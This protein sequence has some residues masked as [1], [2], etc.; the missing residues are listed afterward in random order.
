MQ[1]RLHVMTRQP[2]GMGD[3]FPA[4]PNPEHEEPPDMSK[5]TDHPTSSEPDVF[6]WP[7]AYLEEPIAELRSTIGIF[8]HMIHSASD[9]SRDEWE[10]VHSSLSDYARQ[11]EKLWQAAWDK[12]VAE[13]RAH[14]AALAALEAKKAAPG[15]P[16]GAR[17][18]ASR[19]SG[20]AAGRGGTVMKKPS[21][22][23]R[24]PPSEA[25][26]DLIVLGE[27]LQMFDQ[28]DERSS[29]RSGR[30]GGAGAARGRGRRIGPHVRRQRRS[31]RRPA[32]ARPLV[33][34]PGAVLLAR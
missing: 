32:P 18:L 28:C 9:V 24:R 30:P 25:A 8:H 6:D 20:G 22:G 10:T 27:I 3:A 26:N 7:I 15:T 2:D 14:E 4:W 5:A 21:D 16:I 1:Q 31:T 23:C 11:I 12:N 29:R 13:K 19:S 34:C 33:R 17:R